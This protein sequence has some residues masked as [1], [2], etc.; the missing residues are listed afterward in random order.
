M[1][2]P[3]WDGWGIRRIDAHRPPAARQD[4]RCLPCTRRAA[5][6]SCPPR[7]A[8]LYGTPGLAAL[9]DL[10]KRRSWLASAGGRAV[11]KL[12][13]GAARRSRVP[14]GAGA[15]RLG[16]RTGD[17]V[18]ACV[19]ACACVRVYRFKLHATRGLQGGGGAAPTAD[20]RAD[21]WRCFDELPGH[22]TLDQTLA[23]VCVRVRVC[24]RACVRVCV[25]VKRLLWQDKCECE[26]VRV[27]QRQ[28][29]GHARATTQ[30][31]LHTTLLFFC[32]SE[33]P[34]FYSLPPER[35]PS[36]QPPARRRTPLQPLHR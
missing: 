34:P 2:R 8:R 29:G 33:A 12:G 7:A 27:R 21:G 17:G 36:R 1:K 31:A 28:R 3:T 10:A 13:T 18:R 16:V 19:R 25:C 5:L 35:S 20:R 9:P 26:C 22:Q 14:S 11:M 6:P 23:C 30:R 4:R 32:I 15:W 24:V